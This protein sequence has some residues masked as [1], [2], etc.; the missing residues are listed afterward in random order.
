MTQLALLARLEA[1]PGK[2]ADVQRFLEGALPL[3]QA[4]AGTTSWFALRLGPGTFG[5][6]DTFDTEQARQAHLQGPIASALM[7][8]AGEL[9]VRPPSIEKVDVLAAKPVH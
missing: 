8:R 2:E 5:I 4:E 3:A 7:A 6:Y 9:L 1:K